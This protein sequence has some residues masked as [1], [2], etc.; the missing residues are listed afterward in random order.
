[1]QPKTFQNL[2]QQKLL[3]LLRKKKKLSSMI[4]AEM[5]SIKSMPQI[6]QSKE[7][8]NSKNSFPK[9]TRAF[10]SL[11]QGAREGVAKLKAKG[12]PLPD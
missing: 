1:M 9:N 6:P 5:S 12:L 3:T 11:I 2:K 7:S 4:G 8:Q 10:V